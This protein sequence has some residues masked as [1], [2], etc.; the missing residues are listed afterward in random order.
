MHANDS[1][2]LVKDIKRCKVTGGRSESLPVHRRVLVAPR[3]LADEGRT[4]PSSTAALFLVLAR[5]GVWTVRP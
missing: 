3:V 5:V 2:V 4:P 1:E